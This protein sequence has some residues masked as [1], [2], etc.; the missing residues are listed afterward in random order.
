MKRY[1]CWRAGVPVTMEGGRCDECSSTKH[2]PIPEGECGHFVPVSSTHGRLCVL[3][4]RHAG[5]HRAHDPRFP[6]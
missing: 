1:Y 4:E 5:E 2:D 3:P 6:G